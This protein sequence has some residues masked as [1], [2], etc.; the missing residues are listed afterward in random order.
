MTAL[1]RVCKDL[2]SK[3]S[4]LHQRQFVALL[5]C[6][7]ALLHTQLQAFASDTIVVA[8][9]SGVKITE[10]SLER[11]FSRE[12]GEQAR[13][14]SERERAIL[15]IQFLDKTIDRKLLLAGAA[16]HGFV[17]SG[18]SI[19]AELADLKKNHPTKIGYLAFLSRLNMTPDEMRTKV[20]Q[21]VCIRD[22]LNRYLFAKI[23]VSEE[24]ILGFYGNN[25]QIFLVPEEVRASHIMLAL[26]KHAPETRVAEVEN[27]ARRILSD[28]RERP[29]NFAELAR[30]V[31]E[32]PSRT[33]G[34]DLGYFTAGQYPEDFAQ[35]A[36]N[37]K[38]GE[39]SEPIRA[40]SGIHIIKV[41]D[42]R[43]EM[44]PALTEVRDLVESIVRE[45]KRTEKLKAHLADLK[46]QFRP[47]VYIEIE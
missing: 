39:I 36:F 7:W 37:L 29:S 38:I 9:V 41:T 32:A 19:D 22:Y 18:K 10:G 27:E 30:R 40:E 33:K 21:D 15:R 1:P 31:S 34:G 35:A 47:I 45:N 28:A 23:S 43:A 11:D 20:A 25:R 6:A 42:R 12:L 24:E 13:Y 5:F 46:M 3:S 8:E 4:A 16:A 14:L 44:L 26:A 2:Y 17:P